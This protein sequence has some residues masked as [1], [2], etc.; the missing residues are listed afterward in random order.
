MRLNLKIMHGMRDNSFGRTHQVG[1]KK[2]NEL[3]LYDMSG[4]VLELVWD[5]YDMELL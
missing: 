4:N 3:G 5:R 1:Q 2:P